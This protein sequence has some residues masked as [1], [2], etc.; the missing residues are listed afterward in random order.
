[1]KRRGNGREGKRKKNRKER[2]K[3]RG[4]EEEEKRKRRE[5][6]RRERTGGR[7]TYHMQ[8]CILQTR[9][10]NIMPA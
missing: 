8:K 10:E 9:L 1:V 6:K 5:E 3:R 4:R 2:S 7:T